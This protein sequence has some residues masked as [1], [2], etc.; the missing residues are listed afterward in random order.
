MPKT[1]LSKFVE[2][3]EQADAATLRRNLIESK[4]AMR[5]YRTNRS[6]AVAL[7][8]SDGW[9]NKRMLGVSQWSMDDVKK[10]DNVLRF[11]A[12]ELARLIRC[13]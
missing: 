13:R 2:R 9:L 1:K 10:L 12:D 5:G 8:V 4:A 11:D 7:G 3:D 6:V